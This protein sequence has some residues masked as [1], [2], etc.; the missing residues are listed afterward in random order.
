LIGG[1]QVIALIRR[2]RKPP[3]EQAQEEQETPEL[4]YEPQAASNRLE[5]Q[6]GKTRV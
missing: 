5:K 4:L 6:T 2:A 1:P 3:L